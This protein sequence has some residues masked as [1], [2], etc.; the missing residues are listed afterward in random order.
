MSELEEFRC[1]CLL[2][3]WWDRARSNLV[4]VW[5]AGELLS[6][7]SPDSLQ[8]IA[9]I[10]VEVMMAIRWLEAHEGEKNRQEKP[11]KE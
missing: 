5:D 3:T 10:I 1:H 7:G 2:Q 11:T 9:I 8:R 6:M 4:L